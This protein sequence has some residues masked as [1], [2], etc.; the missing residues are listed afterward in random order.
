MPPDS[1]DLNKFAELMVKVTMQTEAL[2]RLAIAI[3]ERDMVEDLRSVLRES[4]TSG[5]HGPDTMTA[6]AGPPAQV[7]V[8]FPGERRLLLE[9]NRLRTDLGRSGTKPVYVAVLS[10]SNRTL[11]FYGPAVATATSAIAHV[12][13]FELGACV[14]SDGS[15]RAEATFQEDVPHGSPVELRDCWRDPVATGRWFQPVQADPT[16]EAS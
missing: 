4:A 6:P 14:N 7:P 12:G 10:G 1:M 15:T 3:G 13:K 5:G 8:G 2:T 9:Y 16:E 11:R